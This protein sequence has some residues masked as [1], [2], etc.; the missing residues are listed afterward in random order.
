MKPER[1][2]S[3]LLSVLF[4]TSHSFAQDYNLTTEKFV[5]TALTENVGYNWLKELCKIGPRLSG[6]ENSIKA[7]RW[8]ENKMKEC[9]FDSVWLQP[10]MVPHWERG[11]T[12][13][14][15]IAKSKKYGNEKLTIVALGGSIPTPSKGITAEV[16]EVKNFDEVEKLGEKAKGKIIFYN[17][18]FDAG[19]VSTFEGYGKGVDQR[20]EGAIKA[21]KVGAVGVLVRSVQSS[22]DDVP[23]TGS[24][25][26]ETNIN[27]IPGAAISV[28]DADF[29]SKT[30][31]E[32]SG[33]KVTM[34]LDCKT[35]P[36]A[37]SYNVIGELRGSEFPN[38]VIVVGGHFDSWD[39]G[40][41]AHDDGAPSLQ[42]MEVLDIFKRLG[43]KHKRTVRCVLFINEEN[44]LK[45]GI[46]YGK[47]AASSKEKHLA[48]IESDRGAFTPRG[49]SVNTDSLTFQKLQTWLPVLN[50][51]KIDWIRK[52]GSGADVGQVKN[53]KAQFGFV[54]DEQR[55]MDL[56]HS[57][58][59]IFSTVHPREM[60]LGT[61]AM[62]SL[63][64][65]IS[66]AGL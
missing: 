64:F 4:F 24:M 10:V 2:F 1:I 5:R 20:S 48:V 47:Y 44:G 61:A 60:E 56:H 39:K 28:I 17:R 26:Y 34:K 45:G 25:R 58:N 27:K 3:I 49:F 40:C 12:E 35:L 30:I 33:I 51:A 9:K 57:A 37:Q 53:C 62:A 65:L 46:E 59:D 42:T 32:E 54:P 14:A 63:V 52:G 66:E 16:I 15:F 23:H 50:K 18:P 38:E 13:Q 36:D 29:L 43:I 55:Y 22:Y 31:K 11:K 7:I 21:A 8:A 6:S 41:G 19:L